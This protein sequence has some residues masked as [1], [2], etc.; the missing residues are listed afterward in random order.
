MNKKITAL[1]LAAALTVGVGSYGTYAYFTD[2]DKLSE[3]VNITMGILDIESEWVGQWKVTSVGNEAEKKTSLLPNIEFSDDLDYR[4]VKPGDYFTRKVTIKNVG[5]L[6]A[7]AYVQVNNPYSDIFDLE[8]I[9]VNANKVGD[10]VDQNGVKKFDIGNMEGKKRIFQCYD[11]A[12]VEIK[13][14]V[15]NLNND[16]QNFNTESINVDEVIKVYAE[17]L[18]AEQ[19][20]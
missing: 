20:K 1:L 3:N 15:K 11:S 16:W 12:T 6:N 5:N 19:F 2:E 9:P 14:I 17:Q 7:D 8:V 13:L 18:G 4:F 10:I